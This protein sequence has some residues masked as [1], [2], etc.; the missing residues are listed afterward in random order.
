MHSIEYA[1]LPHEGTWEEANTV[2]RGY[3]YNSPLIAIPTERHRG[4]GPAGQSLLGFRGAG[5]VVTAV[6]KAEE[7]NAW[8]VTWYNISDQPQTAELTLPAKP[9]AIRL[10]NTMEEDGE[11]VP[12]TNRQARVQT[13]AKG[14]V[15]L[16][17]E[18]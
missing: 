2:R 9:K 14:L 8:I 6:K 1:L 13:P 17:V 10:S 4:K 15:V 3:E 11:G 12:V 5:L 16:K 7:S 18:W